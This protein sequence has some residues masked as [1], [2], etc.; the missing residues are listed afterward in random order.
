MTQTV[1]HTPIF[2]KTVFTKTVFTKTVHAKL[3]TKACRLLAGLAV[4]TTMGLLS[5]CQSTPTPMSATYHGGASRTYDGN[6]A[7]KARTNLAAQYIRERKLDHARQQLEQAFEA[8][9]RYAPA[10]D[11][12]GVLLQAEGSPAN[13]AKA[14][15]YFRRAI[16]LDK[17]FMPARNN[18][19]Q[20]LAK[21]GRD[22]EAIAQFEVA[23][24]TL[25]YEGRS[26][27]L[28]NLG[29]VYLKV[30]NYPKAKDA[31][32]RSID[33][34]R[35]NLTA[36]VE[37]IDMLLSE[38]NTLLA[39][40]VYDDLLNLAGNQDL[41]ARVLM[42]GIKLAIS[43]NNQAAQ[44][45]LSQQLLATHPLSDEAKRLKAWLANPDRPLR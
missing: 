14:D 45:R 10:Y 1:L 4:M 35:N 37:L 41:P 33:A 16:A 28:E 42:Q 24:T 34:D 43:Q 15:D 25:G 44:Q 6:E 31:F 30:K 19:G 38:K 7:A 39:K 36:R 21:M 2:V 3:S 8:N 11:M 18:Y 23:G 26:I 40:N 29:V 13:M 9:N 32:I 27:A 17:S 20:Y 5:A 12:M 22:H